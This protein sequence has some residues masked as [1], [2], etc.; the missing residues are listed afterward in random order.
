MTTRT[1]AKEDA[2]TAD[3]AD[4]RDV[5]VIT[6]AQGHLDWVRD[7]IAHRAPELGPAEIA[8]AFRADS[9][10]WNPADDDGPSDGATEAWSAVMENTLDAL[11]EVEERLEALERTINGGQDDDDERGRGPDR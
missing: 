10:A 1:H 6:T 9:G 5:I 8:D 2:M 4:D 3:P 7:L 11:I